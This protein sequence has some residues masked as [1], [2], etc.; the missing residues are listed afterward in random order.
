MDQLGPLN[1]TEDS[2]LNTKRQT[3]GPGKV[4]G[5][6]P[7]RDKG[8][9][10]EVPKLSNPAG[11]PPGLVQQVSPTS[12]MKIDPQAQGVRQTNTLACS[13]K[14]VETFPTDGKEA[15]VGGAPMEV[16]CITSN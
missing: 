15:D 14:G 10:T 11:Q 5:V 16:T 7:F 13:D 9:Q 3:S 6:R 1:M 4:G 8:R 12:G 2:Q